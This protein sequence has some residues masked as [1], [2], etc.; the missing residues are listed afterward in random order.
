[1]FINKDMEIGILQMVEMQVRAYN[2]FLQLLEDEEL[3]LKHTKIMMDA[4]ML[5]Q[6]GIANDRF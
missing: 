6:R 3:A 1:M 4:S 5:G 2:H